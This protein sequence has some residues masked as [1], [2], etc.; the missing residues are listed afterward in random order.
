[1]KE[2]ERPTRILARISFA[3]A[4][5]ASV[6]LAFSPNFY[7][8]VEVSSTASGEGKFSAS[9]IEING[10]DVVLLLII[11]VALA[12]SGLFGLLIP[13]GLVPFSIRSLLWI[14][15]ILLGIFCLVGII[16]IGL[17]YLPAEIALVAAAV[18]APKKELTSLDKQVGS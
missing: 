6:W 17:F 13:R 11:P 10:L 2:R 14:P 8:G 9:L 18:M 5:V 12:G 16:T 7:Q 1:M 3:C 15:A 4:A